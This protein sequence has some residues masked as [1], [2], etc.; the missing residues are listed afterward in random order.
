MLQ[1]SQHTHTYTH[2][3]ALPHTLCHTRTHTTHTH[4]T[5]FNLPCHT[6]S[7]SQEEACW[8]M[9]FLSLM[10]EG[11]FQ[12]PLPHTA[13]THAHALLHHLHTCTH[14]RYARTHM[15]AHHAAPAT[16]TALSLHCYHARAPHT[17]CA[18]RATHAAHAHT[19]RC[20]TACHRTTA[21]RRTSL[22]RTARTCCLPPTAALHLPAC[23]YAHLS[24]LSA[25]FSPR[26]HWLVVTVATTTPACLANTPH[27]ITYPVLHLLPSAAAYLPSGLL[28]CT[29]C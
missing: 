20:R 24:P 9:P 28:P 27:P 15:R 23:H 21:C 7:P 4:L 29:A 2:C 16:A 18:P 13:R 12:T 22:A 1:A 11:R 17:H 5:A 19:A 6:A 10:K 26:C 3:T 25:S 14:T 8:F